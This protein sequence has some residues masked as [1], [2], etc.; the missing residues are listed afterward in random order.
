LGKNSKKVLIHDDGT[1]TDHR[2]ILSRVFII[3]CIILTGV[4]VLLGI[5]ALVVGYI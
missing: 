1:I 3:I 2:D 5:G 4:L